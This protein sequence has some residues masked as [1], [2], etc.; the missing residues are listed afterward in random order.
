[1]L[2]NQC[3]TATAPAMPRIN[4]TASNFTPCERIR[5][6]IW[7]RCPRA[8]GGRRFPQPSQRVGYDPVEADR[9][10][11]EREGAKIVRGK[12]AMHHPFHDALSIRRTS[13]SRLRRID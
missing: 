9:G 3:E 12:R 1:M 4:P 10:Q 13:K 6:W 2:R 11:A 8:R 7:K 5:C